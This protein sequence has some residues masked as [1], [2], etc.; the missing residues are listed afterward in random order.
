[1][2]V[3]LGRAWLAGR[4]LRTQGPGWLAFRVGHALRLRSGLLRRQLP[5]GSWEDRPLADSLTDPSL[6]RPGDYL[7]HRLGGSPPFFFAPEDRPPYAARLRGWDDG[8]TG[9]VARGD[10]F[11]RGVLRYFEGVPVTTGFPPDW[12]ANPFTGERLPDDCHWSRIGDFARG[13]IKAVWEPSRFGF[14][15]A[16]VRAY[17]RT[18]DEAHAERFWGLVED[19]RAHN[20]PQTGANWKCGQ[21]VSLRVMAWCFGLYGLL[22]ARAATAGRVAALAQ[23]V[24]VSGRRIEAV[25]GYALSQRNNHGV[26]E[27]V[28]LWTIGLLFPELRDAA[29][30]RER[31]R[32]VLE[33]LGRQLIGE[34]G[35]FSQH[36]FNY[37]RVMLHG[38]LWAVRLGD[39]NG[40]PLSP[41]LRERVGRA[42]ELLYQVQD[43]A[44]GRVPDYGQNDGAIVLPLSNCGPHDYRPVVQA[45]RFLTTATRCLGDGPWDEDLLWLFGPGALSGPVAA[46]AR[47]DLAAEV[48]GYYTL[49]SDRGFAFARCAA[50]R[51]RPGQADLLHVDLWWRGQNVAL[52]P[53]T[54]SYNAPPPWDNALA[55]TA[56]H[57]TVEVDGKSQM[58]LVGRFLWVPWARGRVRRREA[59]AGGRLAYWEG[60]HDGYARLADP[61]VHRRGVLRLGD[62]HWLVLDGLQSRGD[63]LYRL[64]WLLPDWPAAW[65]PASESGGPLGLSG[66]LK[67][68]TPAGP[69]T[70]TLGWLG[71]SKGGSS[72]TRAEANGPRGWRAPCYLA[73][74]P[75]ISLAVVRRAADLQF[76]TVFG[77][78]GVEVT[79]AADALRVEG[80]GW[81]ADVRLG[82]GVRSSLVLGVR[83]IRAGEV[84]DRLGGSG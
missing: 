26:I 80:P 74:E 37:Q 62:E 39:L 72:L 83:L 15:Y 70:V 82:D 11:G 44:S 65:E 3:L 84:V 57:N 34:D 23:A 78:P 47:T 50:F 64:N 31:G 59:S 19:W 17:W 20:P 45:V 5:A 63:H 2:E 73:R 29:R 67:L 43:E 6:A 22:A 77:P 53:G 54:F 8:R 21:E 7:A 71:P 81:R 36:S 41:G 51:H 9:P 68:E 12:H 35:S 79:P 1:M 27:G 4:L 16:L 46:T 61:A 58:D 55:R 76:W 49:R 48:G 42:G 69:Y 56:C 52:D 25:L 40:R 18:G 33:R 30:W 38:Y 66:R 14:A 75:A 32:R 60:E 10:E 13:D 24:A 28:G